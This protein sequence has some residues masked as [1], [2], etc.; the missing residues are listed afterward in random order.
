MLQRSVSDL[1][2]SA[3]ELVFE[4][5]ET[6]AGS[7]TPL[8]ERR[9]DCP[10]LSCFRREDDEMHVLHATLDEA[11]RARAGCA[12]A[13]ALAGD[14][15][16]P[17]LC[18]QVHAQLQTMLRQLESAAA[19]AL[20][21][22]KV[23]AAE[24]ESIIDAL[25][26]EVA[27]QEEAARRFASSAQ[28]E[29]ATNRAMLTQHMDS[30]VCLMRGEVQ[31]AERH[32]TAA[33]RVIEEL[34]AQISK[35][36][37]LLEGH[38][39]NLEEERKQRIE[40]LYWVAINRVVKLQMSRGFNS[41]VE[42]SAHRKWLKMRAIMAFRKQNLFR[43]MRHWKHVHPPETLVQRVMELEKALAK[44]KS[45]HDKLKE[46]FKEARKKLEEHGETL[47]DERH[48][49]ILHLQVVALRRFRRLELARGWTRWREVYDYHC[50][51]RR[52]A[53]GSFKNREL[54]AGMRSWVA[55]YPPRISGWR[56]SQPLEAR[57]NELERTLSSERAMLHKMQTTSAKLLAE[58]DIVRT[59]VKE[60]SQMRHVVDQLRHVFTEALNAPSWTTCRQ[61]LYHESLRYV[62]T[63]AT[64][65]STLTPTQRQDMY[66]K[67]SSG[68]LVNGD[69]IAVIS[70]QVSR[71]AS[72][73]QRDAIAD[74]LLA[75]EAGMTWELGT[76][77]DEKPLAESM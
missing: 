50:W 49:R 17:E 73:A 42:M 46:K 56:V 10:V 23:G 44:E 52:R 74:G 70:K 33:E 43:A 66:S 62:P 2:G 72:T 25:R 28:Q 59:A 19:V 5:R 45:V 61:V 69:D 67:N 22:A 27:A 34:E 21:V 1:V 24:R 29:L 41:W 31:I 68:V 65:G 18:R 35:R 51:L 30:E 47:S 53:L 48:Q 58:R 13:M 37:K 20:S 38:Q 39:G 11:A 14:A 26:C 40:H 55:V 75:R 4:H 6:R 54:A 9:R 15:G 60:C 76:T 32:R 12:H 77:S 63:A 71:R 57:I 7:R 36:D 3:Q 8:L 64:H 16:A